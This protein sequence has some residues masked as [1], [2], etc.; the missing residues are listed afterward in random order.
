ML[1]RLCLLVPLLLRPRVLVEQVAAWMR[2]LQVNDEAVKTV[3]AEKLSGLDVAALSVD[4]LEVDLRCTR[5]QAKKLV[6][7]IT[8]MRQEASGESSLASAGLVPLAAGKSAGKVAAPL[9]VSKAPPRQDWAAVLDDKDAGG[10]AA[11][12]REVKAGA[13]TSLT[14]KEAKKLRKEVRDLKRQKKTAEGAERAR[15][16]AEIAALEARLLEGAE[17]GGRDY[18]DYTDLTGDGG[19]RLKMLKPGSGLQPQALSKVEVH[20]VGKVQGGEEFHSTHASG[21]AVSFLLGTSQTIKG[22]EVAL[23][24]MR[25]GSRALVVIAPA[26]GYGS[27]GRAP[28]DEEPEV[29]PGATLEYELSLIS[30]LEKPGTPASTA[31]ALEAKNLERLEQVWVCARAR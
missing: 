12:E 1:V 11:E 21:H 8:Q 23:L 19:V 28:R 22:L 16:K 18:S 24:A 26:Y 5:L 14:E 15:L 20:F 3:E 4:E 30:F 2:E 13:G 9:S 31:S 10:T 6:N 27:K 29:P 7:R 25:A 17:G